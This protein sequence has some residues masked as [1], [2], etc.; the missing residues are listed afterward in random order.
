M[1]VLII[2]DQSAILESLEMYFSDKG[3][4]TITAEYGAE[5]LE[6]VKSEIPDI[7]IL[8]VRLPDINGLDVLRKI[9]TINKAIFVIVITAFHDMKTT[10]EAMKN[11]AYD[12]ILK[13]INIKELDNSVEKVL[14]AKNVN[15]EIAKSE[16]G[17]MD[18]YNVE[19]IIGK[20]KAIQEIFK[21]IGLS[22]KSN[23]TVL[24][25]GESG[26]GKELIARA[27]HYNSILKDEPFV[28]INCC[29]LMETLLESELFGH[30]K[31]AFTNAIQEKRGKFE[32]A[33]KGTIFLDEV[34]EL[35]LMTQAKLLRFL[36]E[37]QFERVG[38]ER[39]ISSEARIIAASNKNLVQMVR[40]GG[41]REDLYFRLKVI[42]INVP[43]LRER[44]S[45]IPMLVDFFLYKICKEVGCEQKRISKE[46][47]DKLMNHRWTGNVRELE[48]SIKRSVILS[49]G[50][51]IEGS[52]IIFESEDAEVHS[53]EQERRFKSMEDVEKDHIIWAL[54][55]AGGNKGKTCDLLKISR[56][57]LNKK[58][59][60]YDILVSS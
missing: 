43:A 48:N 32:L 21:I 9:K 38:G 5:G 20:S 10:I 31:G 11:G 24:I 17:E 35:S 12:Y 4:D 50:D 39:V 15:K 19:T 14:E 59:E 2:D 36:Q 1:K 3:Y 13:P 47:L 6:K 16:Y 27:I 25:K 34:G 45:D 28:G 57:T 18:P 26:T 58:I 37:K 41:F 7:V 53:P 51:I 23:S 30:E 60:K 44:K 46:V 55:V 49:V 22:C 40:E 8:D 56:P 33:G 52:H 54:K 42:T 29:A